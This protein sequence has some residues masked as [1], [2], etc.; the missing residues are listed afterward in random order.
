MLLVLLMGMADLGRVFF[1]GI[2]VEAVARNAAE[3]AAQ[4]YVQLVRNK[5]GG[6]LDATDYDHLHQVALKSACSEA[7]VLP[8]QTASGGICT[9]PVAAVCVHDGLDPI[10]GSEAAGAPSDCDETLGPWTNANGGAAAGA[11]PA[12][13]YVEV[14][15]CYR[16]TT[17]FSSV[18]LPLGWSINLGEIWLQRG[19]QFA[20]A[21]Y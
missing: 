11:R 5:V 18:S 7:E 6:T 19:R 13:V 15:I 17:L 1:A 12:L 9:M 16:F 3:S 2:T 20:A 21:N 14:R 4:E 10:C 8:N